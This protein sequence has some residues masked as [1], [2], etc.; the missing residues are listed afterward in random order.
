MDNTDLDNSKARSAEET[1]RKVNQDLERLQEELAH[2]LSQD[3]QPLGDRG[4]R[5]LEEI[6][7]LEGL[8]HRLRSQIESKH[9]EQIPKVPGPSAQEETVNPPPEMTPKPKPQTKDGQVVAGLLL[10]F[11]SACVLSLFNVTLKILLKLSPEPRLVLGVFPVDGLITPGLGNSLLILFLRMIVIML[12]FPI[13]ATVLYPSVWSDIKRFIE[14]NDYDHMLKVVGSGFFLFLSQVCIYIAIGNIPT[15]IAITIFFIYPIVTVF[16][17]WALFGDRP[18][19]ARIIAMAVI[20]AGGIMALPQGGIEGNTQL[21]IAAAVGAGVTFAGYVLLVGMGTKK[22]HPIPF[23]LVSF[24]AIFVF[25][26]ISL[27]FP[28]PEGLGVVIEPNTQMGLLIG[29]TILGLLTLGSY[30]LNNFA[31]RFAGPALASI[32]GASGPALTALFSLFLIAE[33]L[34]TQQ[35]IGLGLVSLGVLGMSLERMLAPKKA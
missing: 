9:L 32:V 29:G 35:W 24:A 6:R 5:L 4:A 26:G 2:Q 12:V 8:A 28:L 16:A 19:L 15:G 17:S 27:L 31:I 14:S 1:L 7:T 18:N 3:G 34:R 10:A 11:L 20:L 21:G 22:L 30:L 33:A 25:S 23:S 13:L